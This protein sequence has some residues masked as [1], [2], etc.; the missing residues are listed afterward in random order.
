ME[1]ASSHYR[2]N[3]ITNAVSRVG[4]ALIQQRIINTLVT[5]AD[6]RRLFWVK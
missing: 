3:V 2:L 5:V 1:T 6:E 4:F